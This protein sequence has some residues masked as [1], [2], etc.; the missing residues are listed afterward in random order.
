[1]TGICSAVCITSDMEFS[2]VHET[3]GVCAVYLPE[4]ALLLL[5]SHTVVQD[6]EL[7]PVTVK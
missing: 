6:F 1:M 2:D 3:V 7:F 5:T 4:L